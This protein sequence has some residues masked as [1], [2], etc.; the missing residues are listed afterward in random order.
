MEAKQ[1][2]GR[3]RQAKG[4]ARR[5]TD[6][7]FHDSYTASQL[8]SSLAEQIKALRGD[9]SQQEFGKLLGKPQ[10]V[11]SR[12]EELHYGKVTIQTLLDIAAKLDV[13][14]AVQFVSRRTYRQLM[15][16]VSS[17]PLRPGHQTSKGADR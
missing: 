10:S 12:L 17:E 1:K 16:L 13:V 14:L 5:L 3:S 8:K 2:K 11:V 15:D 7:E 6:K 4:L 9:M